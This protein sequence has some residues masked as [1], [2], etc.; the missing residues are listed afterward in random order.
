LT[1]RRFTRGRARLPLQHGG[2]PRRVEWRLHARGLA[3]HCRPHCLGL[4]A[5]VPA[6]QAV[7][8]EKRDDQRLQMVC[9]GVT[10]AGFPVLD[11]AATHAHARRQLALGQA[12]G[13]APQSAAPGSKLIAHSWMGMTTPIR[14]PPRW[15]KKTDELVRHV[16]LRCRPG[17]QSEL[18][19]WIE[20]SPRFATFIASNQDKVRKKLNT[21]EDEEARLDVRAELLVAYLILADRRFDLSFEAYGARHLGPD[22]TVTYR[23][24]QRFNL[25]VTRLRATGDPDQGRLASVITAKVRQLPGDLPNALVITTRGLPITEES[26]TTAARLLKAHTDHKDDAF[27]A[28]RGLRDARD[29]YAHYVHLGGVFVLDEATVPAR[30]VFSA[31]RDARRPLPAEALARLTTCLTSASA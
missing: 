24:N 23:A 13:H 1:G 6:H 20:V 31:N 19:H 11:R 22:L 17:L 18:A 27:F 8:L 26:L 25:E 12:C 28:R 14:R 10:H 2:P 7:G 15:S 4:G 29:F 16:A 21:C 3:Q 9:V 5:L 30:T